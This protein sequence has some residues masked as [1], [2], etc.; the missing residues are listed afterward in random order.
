[1]DRN[2]L[3]NIRR[4]VVLTLA[5]PLFWL[6]MILL[7]ILPDFLRKSIDRFAGKIYY[8]RSHRARAVAH[9]NIRSVYPELSEQEVVEMSQKV[10]HNIVSTLFDFFSF[11]M[12]KDRK[13]FF[14]HVRVEGEEHLKEAYAKGK[15][16]ICLI[17]HIS[18]WELSAVTPPMLGYDTVAA[19]KPVK[20]FLEQRTMVWF[21]RRRKMK[22]LDR[23]GSYAQLL[24][25]LKEGK[26]LILMIDQDTRVKGCFVEFFGRETFTPLGASRLVA[27]TGAAVVP[28]SM[29]RVGLK[30]YVFH[31]YPALK[32]Q[33]TSDREQDLVE[34]TQRQSTMIEQIIRK[35]PIQWVWMHRR[36][37]TT[38][39]N[40]PL[41]YPKKK[42]VEK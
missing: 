20:G 42:I 38:P 26:C 23:H 12:V 27:D 41:P 30:Q 2:K 15:G 19:S 17:P 14:R 10:F 37:K 9:E 13:R 6:I 18:S 25:S 39:Q 21:R 31:I 28:M 40:Y 36:W 7:W 32:M 16:V 33:H 22:N 4:E 1:M 3:N 35:N 34:N 29:E 8:N 24:E 5:Y 11:V